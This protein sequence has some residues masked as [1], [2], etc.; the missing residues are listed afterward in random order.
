MNL[1]RSECAECLSRGL[2]CLNHYVKGQ[3]GPGVVLCWVVEVHL[4]PWFLGLW[5]PAPNMLF[6]SHVVLPGNLSYIT[7]SVSALGMGADRCYTGA[8][9]SVA[10]WQGHVPWQELQ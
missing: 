8:A 6:G 10:N 3:P 1:Q 9:P 2:K 5:Q 4:R 7:V